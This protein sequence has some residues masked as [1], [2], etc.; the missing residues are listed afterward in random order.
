MNPYKNAATKYLQ[1]NEW[2]STPL[3]AARNA[4]TYILTLRFLVTCA[5]WLV[6]ILANV[7][8]AVFTTML[9]AS[10]AAESLFIVATFYIVC[11]QFAH[12]LVIWLIGDKAMGVCEQASMVIFAALP[13]LIVLDALKTSYER[14]RFARQTEKWEDRGWAIATAIPSVVFAVM[15]IIALSSFT[16]L[17]SAG[18]AITQ[19]T[20]LPLVIRIITGWVYAFVNGLYDRIGSNNYQN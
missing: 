20:G 14:Y 8:E 5:E 9:A 2:I 12:S 1:D 17:E 11:D 18:K 4:L 16:D 15:M 3:D 19:V 6:K 7:K 10:K 13:E